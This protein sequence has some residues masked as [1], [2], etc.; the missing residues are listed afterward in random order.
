[1][2]IEISHHDCPNFLAK[3]IL[4]RCKEMGLIFERVGE[5]KIVLTVDESLPERPTVD[6]LII[7]S[8]SFEEDY[9]W[10]TGCRVLP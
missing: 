10:V 3:S 5:K 4:Q 7:L 1:M 2:R 8:K 9:E 6:E